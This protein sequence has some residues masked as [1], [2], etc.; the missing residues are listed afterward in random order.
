MVFVTATPTTIICTWLQTADVTQESHAA[1]DYGDAHAKG[2]KATQR[3]KCREAC[4]RGPLALV[5]KA[6]QITWTRPSQPIPPTTPFFSRRLPA[7]TRTLGTAERLSLAPVP[8]NQR[9]AE[10]WSWILFSTRCDGTTRPYPC[11]PTNIHMAAWVCMMMGR[12]LAWRLIIGT[13]SSWVGPPR[14]MVLDATR[15]IGPYA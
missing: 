5:V 13:S 4:E 3:V 7:V 1:L 11:Q 12:L 10:I 14:A 15:G 2:R 6:V 9:D 8:S